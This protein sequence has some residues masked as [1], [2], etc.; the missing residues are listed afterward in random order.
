MFGITAKQIRGA[1][2]RP[3]PWGVEGGA[4]YGM[5]TPCLVWHDDRPGVMIPYCRLETSSGKVITAKTIRG[6]KGAARRLGLIC[7]DDIYAP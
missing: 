1:V 7:N 6:L 3:A 2:V 4:H 5:N